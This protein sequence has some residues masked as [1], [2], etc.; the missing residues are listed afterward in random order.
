MTTLPLILLTAGYA[1]V[2]VLAVYLTRATSLRVA[3]ALAGGAAAG[4][5]CLGLIVLGEALRWWKVPLLSTPFLL[6]LGL[7]ISVSPIYL[8]TWRIVRRFGWRGLALFTAVVTIIGAPR[9]YFIASKFPEWMVFSPGIV[10]IIAD[11]VTYGAVIVLLG[12]AVMRLISGPAR[13]DL[14]ARS[15]PLGAS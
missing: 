10:P 4:L 6:F 8:V 3:G 15:Q 2:F 9:D 7:A 13:E 5:V 1:L 12:H 14:L 11:A